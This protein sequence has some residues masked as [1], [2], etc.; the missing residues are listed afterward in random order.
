MTRREALIWLG[1]LSGSLLLE[2]SARALSRLRP[3]KAFTPKLR[4]VQISDLHYGYRGPGNPDPEGSLLRAFSAVRRLR[5]DI[6]LV[7]GDLIQADRDPRVRERRLFEVWERLSA[8]GFPCLAVPGEQDALP[9][10]GALWKRVVGPLYFHEERGGVHLIGLDNVSEGYLIG[11]K[12][13]QWLF[14]Q[15]DH[16]DGEA[17]VLVMAHAP[18]AWFYP[19]WNWYTY[20]GPAV[21]TLFE[22]FSRRLFVHG[23]VHQA[24]TDATAGLHG[25]GCPAVSFGYPLPDRREPAPLRPVSMPDDERDGGLGVRLIEFSGKFQMMEH[26]LQRPVVLGQAR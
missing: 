25:F 10:R 23:H 9:D 26:P 17:P 5:P 11:A 13:R 7:T 1:A 14:D 8:L 3:V 19:P 22:R 16:L 20:N 15:V 4:A 12:E 2:P 6:L 18:L 24:L 21:A